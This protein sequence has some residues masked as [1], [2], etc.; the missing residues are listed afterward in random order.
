MLASLLAVLA[1]AASLAPFPSPAFVTVSPAELHGYDTVWAFSDIHGS[2]GAMRALLLKAGLAIPQ[3]DHVAWAPRAKRQLV[4]AVGDY[5]NGGRESVGVVFQL[6]DLQKQA[7]AAGSRII[8]L[9]GNQEAEVLSDPEKNVTPEV[10]KSA[11]AFAAQL[12]L[13]DKVKPK[14]LVKSAFGDYLRTLPAGALVGSVLFVHSGDLDG[15]DDP[16]KALKK[17]G[18][19]FAPRDE[20][21]YESLLGDGSLVGSHNWWKKDKHRAEV[22]AGWAALGVT[23][24]VIGHDPDALGAFGSAA[25][26]RDGF[27]I[28]IDAGIKDGNSKGRLLKCAAAALA[29]PALLASGKPVC[30]QL[31]E[32]GASSSLPLR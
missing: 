19:K 7:K 30:S 14:E 28:K 13:G 26:S 16:K 31:N 20:K 24:L 10:L 27:L 32:T 2:L 5:L 29:G 12:G 4:I 25:Q 11:K 9:L 6:R 23:G 8:V 3:G 18:E 1:A 21:A 15:K 17:I 22:Q